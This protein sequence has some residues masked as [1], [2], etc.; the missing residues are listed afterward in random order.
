[1]PVIKIR[2]EHEELAAIKRRAGELGTTVEALAYGAL[3]C[4]MSH[5]REPFCRVRIDQAVSERGRDLPL[6]SDSARSVAIYE[7]LHDIQQGPGP[8]GGPL[9]AP[10]KAGEQPGRLKEKPKS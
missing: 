4:S 3:N 7:S 2:L 9:D 10:P 5:V 8:N 1:M 6:W